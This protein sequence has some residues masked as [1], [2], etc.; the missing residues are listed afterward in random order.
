MVGNGTAFFG[1]FTLQQP[2]A[3]KAWVE[4]KERHLHFH[5]CNKLKVI[6]WVRAIVTRIRR[7]MDS[8]VPLA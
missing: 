7:I 5:N 3:P 8:D 1:D 4:Q 6:E 2:S